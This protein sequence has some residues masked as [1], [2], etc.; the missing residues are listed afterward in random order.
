MSA[1]T[2]VLDEIGYLN[3]IP[4]GTT[5]ISAGNA[6]CWSA[7]N[8]EIVLASELKNSALK[9]LQSRFIFNTLNPNPANNI[10]NISVDG[11]P[12]NNRSTISLLSVSGVVIKTIRSS[13]LNKITQMNVSSLSAGV[14][15][16]KVMNGGKILYKQFV[17]I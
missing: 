6:C 5:G 16:I 15:Y 9:W 7:V 2:E 10:L 12:A 11:F 4:I 13:S 3:P 14:Y 8:P 17:K 1:L